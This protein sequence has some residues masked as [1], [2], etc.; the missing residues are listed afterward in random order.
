MRHEQVDVSQAA[1]H[2]AFTAYVA[3]RLPSWRRLGTGLLVGVV[4]TIAASLIL[5]T[6]AIGS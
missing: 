3:A 1:G 2:D 6:L 4:T 5:L